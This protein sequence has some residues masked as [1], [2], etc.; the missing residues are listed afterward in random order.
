MGCFFPYFSIKNIYCGYWSETPC[1]GASNE[2]HTTIYVFYGEKD[3]IIPELSCRLFQTKSPNGSQENQINYAAMQW[4][5]VY[6]YI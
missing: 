1:R 5:L 3:K 2:Y 4:A 6:I